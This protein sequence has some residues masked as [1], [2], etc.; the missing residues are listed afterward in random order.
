MDSVN[1]AIWLALQEYG[2]SIYTKPTFDVWFRDAY[3]DRIQDDIIFIKLPSELARNKWKA[4]FEGKIIEI[5]YQV[6]GR[7]L[8]PEFEFPNSSSESITKEHHKKEILNPIMKQKETIVKK[9]RNEVDTV[10]ESALRD[11]KLNPD[12]TFEKFVEAESNKFAY[13]AASVAV[14]QPK[15]FN[16]LFIF[17]D[18]GLGKTH[19]MQAV[20]HDLLKMNPNAKV[21]YIGCDKFSQEYIVSI[22][23]K[24][25]EDFREKY[26][27]LNLLLLDDIQFLENREG[28]QIEFFH[29]FENIYNNGGQII[30]T[31]D[32]PLEEIPNL[33]DR[34]VSRFK[35]GVIADIDPPNY[36]ARIAI[37]SEKARLRGLDISK[38]G[39]EYIANHVKD[40]VRELEGA[41]TNIKVFAEANVQ[42]ELSDDLIREFFSSDHSSKSETTITIPSIQKIVC[43]FYNIT[44][45]DIKGKGRASKF[46]FPRQM[47]MFL[48]RELTGESYPTIGKEFGGRDHTTV[49]HS[50]DKLKIYIQKMKKLLVI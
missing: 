12:F 11:A 25:N 13:T 35:K 48:A 46:V 42:K 28:T 37:L 18:S 26:N 19:L 36:E 34:I 40:N 39:L 5:A 27:N 31:S 9:N 38:T 16:P 45:T 20:G 47:A 2:H 3:I 6:T 33:H 4:D 41:L 29:I 23:N 50:I 10:S 8:L 24:N 30:I 21:R 1:D 17:G 15:L 7:D 14:E 32:R 44:E 22:K 43:D 49:M